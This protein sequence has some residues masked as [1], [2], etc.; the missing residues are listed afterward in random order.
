MAGA[1]AATWVSSCWLGGG[2]AAGGRQRKGGDGEEDEEDEDGSL[3]ATDGGDEF[4]PMKS[5][6]GLVLGRDFD[7]DGPNTFSDSAEVSLLGPVFS[8]YI[9]NIS[10]TGMTCLLG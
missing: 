6:S 2:G 10:N 8:A 9:T 1:A 7:D 3:A 5:M 4:R